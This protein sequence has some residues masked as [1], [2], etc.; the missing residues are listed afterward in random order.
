MTEDVD[1]L[2]GRL[3]EARA[4]V[5]AIEADFDLSPSRAS[6]LEEP[7]RRA[8][9]LLTGYED[10]AT[11]TGD[12][13]GYLEFRANFDEL[14]DG[15]PED[16]PRRSAFEEAQAALD[17]RRLHGH[18][19]DA[20]RAALAPVRE[21]VE[22]LGS[23]R[24]A[25][26]EVGRLRRE[27]EAAA[28]RLRD[29]R[30]HLEE[31]A[32]LD[33]DAL[34][35]PVDELREPIEG[36]NWSVGHDFD[37]WLRSTPARDALQA[38]RRM[39]HFALLDVEDPPSALVDFLETHPTGERPVPRLLELLGYTRSKLA[40]YV[41]DPGG[42]LGALGP[43]ERYLEELS[44]APFRIDWPPPKATT[45]RWTAR[46]LHQAANRFATEDTMATLRTVEELVREEARY[47]RLRVAASARAELD[48]DDRRLVREGEVEPALASVT[49]ALERVTAALED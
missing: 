4:R 18:H 17:H 13:G 36:Y 8:Q 31:L 37:R 11:G 22:T 32:T 26:D 23:L 5:D 48:P 25:R 35:S 30:D 15:L 6:D 38:Y 1:D 28:D 33:A 21:A 39:G 24:E 19:F 44:P 16:L 2:L 27:L 40:H 47:E 14:V 12:F 45:M 3:A 41:D 10:R 7:L 43:H 46:E 49:Q 20:A 29:R 34:D 9:G 42:F